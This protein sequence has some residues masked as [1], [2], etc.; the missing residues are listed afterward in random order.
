M[1]QTQKRK[2]RSVQQTLFGVSGKK[3][4]TNEGKKKRKKLEEKKKLEELLQF[5]ESFTLRGF[6]NGEGEKV[7]TTLPDQLYCS[8]FEEVKPGSLT[9]FV[10]KILSKK[11]PELSSLAEQIRNGDVV[12]P[13][14]ISTL[15][16]TKVRGMIVN[17][18]NR[19]GFFLEILMPCYNTDVFKCLKDK[20]DCSLL[21][22][23]WPSYISKPAKVQGTYHDIQIMGKWMTQPR[24]TL[25]YGK[26]YHYSSVKHAMEAETPEDIQVLLDET[27][28]LFSLPKGRGVNM[29]LRNVYKLA[30]RH[31][32]GEHS[33]DEKSMG[34]LN[35]VFCWCV[36]AGLLVLRAS[37]KKGNTLLQ[38]DPNSS[39][40]KA[41]EILR[42]V[43]PEGL[44]IM[45]GNHFQKE[46]TH[47]FPQQQGGLFKRLCKSFAEDPKRYPTFPR[48][49]SSYLSE[50][51][52]SRLGLLQAEWIADH[53]EVFLE[54]S[55]AKRFS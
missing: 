4:K 41:R 54:K 1:Q 53:K 28:R 9:N 22:M 34:H 43:I 37:K 27:N 21:W 26:A 47:E 50:H 31:G 49:S 36:G 45:K 44:Y 24:W 32:I 13:N 48:V 12:V 40:P 18:D 7:V 55:W 38:S 25:C 17:H 20:C 16:K 8:P 46:Y 3:K 23:P 15:G 11:L 39:T 6:S 51:G 5:R 30:G 42:L 10:L 29:C 19:V 52:V 33:D 14:I 2:K 35:D